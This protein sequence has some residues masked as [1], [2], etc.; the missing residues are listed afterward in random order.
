MK[1][2]EEDLDNCWPYFKVYLIEILNGDYSIDDA[3]DDL[4]SLIGTKY[5]ARDT[6]GID[7]E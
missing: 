5:D 6:G 1:F 2:T 4:R 3:R 7:N